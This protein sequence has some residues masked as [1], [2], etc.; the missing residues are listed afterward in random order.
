[1]RLNAGH[2]KAPEQQLWHS[3]SDELMCSFRSRATCGCRGGPCAHVDRETGAESVWQG[4]LAGAMRG[5]RN[6]RVFPFP[7]INGFCENRFLNLGYNSK[8]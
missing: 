2:G 8:G 4:F 7:S 5:W 3:C 1:M 6:I